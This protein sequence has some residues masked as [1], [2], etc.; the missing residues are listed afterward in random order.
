MLKEV[1]YYEEADSTKTLDLY[2]LLLEDGGSIDFWFP[3]GSKPTT[4]DLH[5]EFERDEHD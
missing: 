1:A 5:V 4:L 3:K 2:E